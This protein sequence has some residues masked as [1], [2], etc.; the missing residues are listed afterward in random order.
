MKDLWRLFMRAVSCQPLRMDSLDKFLRFIYHET[1]RV[2]GDRLIDEKDRS[3][4]WDAQK[5]FLADL[6]KL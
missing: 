6:G 2:F 1:T 5:V 3:I 4:L